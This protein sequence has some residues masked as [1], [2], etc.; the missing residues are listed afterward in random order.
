MN[1]ILRLRHALLVALSAPLVSCTHPCDTLEARVCEVEIDEARCE[2]MQDPD[3][4]PL[5]TRSTCDGILE[6]MGERR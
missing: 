4:R 5:L 2:I 3:R 6:K 1:G